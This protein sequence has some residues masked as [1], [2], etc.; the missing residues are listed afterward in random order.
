MPPVKSG[1]VEWIDRAIALVGSVATRVTVRGE[2][3]RFTHTAQLDRWNEQGTRLF[4][5]G[6]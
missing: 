6:F 4:Y 3:V 1:S 2:T 5:F